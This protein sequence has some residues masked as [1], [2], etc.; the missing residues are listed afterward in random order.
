MSK[1]IRKRS[2]RVIKKSRSRTKRNKRVI[3]KS[4]SRSKRT[5]IV[6]K[7][8]RSRAKRDGVGIFSRVKTYF[9]PDLDV[10]PD[11]CI[12]NVKKLIDY[13]NIPK[14]EELDYRIIEYCNKTRHIDVLFLLACKEGDSKTCNSLL[15]KGAD[16]KAEDIF[17]TTALMYCAISSNIN[18]FNYIIL[19]IDYRD[20]Y[21]NKKDEH[22]NTFLLYTMN[23][24]DLNFYN[25]LFYDKLV[26]YESPT[27]LRM[28][29][30]K[31][32]PILFYSIDRY[33]NNEVFKEYV[34]SNCGN[35]E[36]RDSHGDTSIRY[37][38]KEHNNEILLV[39]IIKKIMERISPF[40]EIIKDNKI[41]RYDDLEKLLISKLGKINYQEYYKL[42]KTCLV[43]YEG[44]NIVLIYASLKGSFL[45]AEI[46]IK[47]IFLYPL[48]CDL[49]YRQDGLY[50]S[51]ETLMGYYKLSDPL[52]YAIING[53]LNIVKLIFEYRFDKTNYWN[54]PTDDDYHVNY[55]YFFTKLVNRKT[56]LMHASEH[57]N[58]DIVKLIIEYIKKCPDLY[59]KNI[60]NDVYFLS[61]NSFKKFKPAI[62]YA[63]SNS[64]FE[65][66]DFL[67]EEG[68]GSYSDN[69]EQC[70]ENAKSEKI[71]KL[72][73]IYGMYMKDNPESNTFFSKFKNEVDDSSNLFKHVVEFLL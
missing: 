24:G 45:T 66:V 16:P 7:K 26:S 62:D 6:I 17:G 30:D 59:V 2:K 20:D 38:A 65:I 31:G 5:K 69:I 13:D 67:V 29:D 49:E 3:K 70:L 63:C 27:Y 33:N 73:S 35:L 42:L 60:I 64:H 58:L 53:H 68:A 1:R 52:T 28:I 15:N 14:K 23:K 37:V 11:K 44:Q 46:L 22:Q 47:L 36:I 50:L 8:S 39:H 21:I 18:I 71:K 57:G 41:V 61:G 55:G 51:I 32:E 9:Y 56:I 72:E 40:K 48:N 19:K 4:R 12:Y 25:Y 10:V 43:N 54:P 34:D